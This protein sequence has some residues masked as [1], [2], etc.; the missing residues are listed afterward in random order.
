MSLFSARGLHGI[1][2]DNSG[3]AGA[4]WDMRLLVCPTAAEDIAL[5]ACLGRRTLAGR[6][7]GR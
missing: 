5:A 4:G 2:P 6:W 3:L 7:G 1:V